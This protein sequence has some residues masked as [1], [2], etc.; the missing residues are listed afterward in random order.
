[1]VK[2]LQEQEKMSSCPDSCIE[3]YCA[4]S[5]Y[6]NVI[7]H[8]LDPVTDTHRRVDVGLLQQWKVADVEII[9]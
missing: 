5:K 7:I 2:C 8:E 9:W 4:S 6:T 1:M 3:I